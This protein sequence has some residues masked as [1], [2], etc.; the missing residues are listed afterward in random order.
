[1]SLQEILDRAHAIFVE[2][3]RVALPIL[4]EVSKQGCGDF[5]EAGLGKNGSA[6]R[7]DNCVRWNPN[8]DS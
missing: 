2:I 1:M 8:E 7:W 4:A 3:S 5:R 6:C